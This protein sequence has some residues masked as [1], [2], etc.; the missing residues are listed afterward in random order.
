M[1]GWPV[2]KKISLFLVL[3]V[4]A[5]LISGCVNKSK[6]ECIMTSTGF[7]RIK[8]VL[9]ETT[10]TTD[11]NLSVIFFNNAGGPIKLI[12]FN[13]VD[14]EPGVNCSEY[15]KVNGVEYLLNSTDQSYWEE[16]HSRVY[17][18]IGSGD[19]FQISTIC[20]IN[21]TTSAG[22]R[23]ILNITM[24]HDGADYDGHLKKPEGTLKGCY[25]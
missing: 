7:V 18:W 17:P 12:H 25:V 2:E 19:K 24:I 23:F 1:V 15:V 21:K 13:V 4:V 16:F 9:N 22:E 8:P 11:G 5:V 14:T 10:L 6:E 20:P 3:A